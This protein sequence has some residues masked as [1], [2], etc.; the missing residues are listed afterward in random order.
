MSKPKSL[1]ERRE[2]N[3]R[4]RLAQANPGSV[5]RNQRNGKVVKQPEKQA[6]RGD[7]G[8]TARQ[9]QKSEIKS[10]K[11]TLKKIQG[12]VKI[13]LEDNLTFLI[14]YSAVSTLL[15]F[16]LLYNF[17]GALF[18][19][20]N[21]WVFVSALIILILGFVRILKLC[22]GITGKN[23]ITVEGVILVL[24]LS[25]T[26]GAF[27]SVVVN[28]RVYLST[29]E[30]AKVHGVTTDMWD[31][32][33]ILASAESLLLSVG[34]ESRAFYPE[35][36]ERS[37][38]LGKISVKWAKI[39]QQGSLPAPGLVEAASQLATS[40]DWGSRALIRKAQNIVEP[41]P[42]AEADVAEW[43][44]LYQ[45]SGS[46]AGETVSRVSQIYGI[47]LGDIS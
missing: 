11:Q 35:M 39:S 31:D 32:L 29:S 44:G 17:S 26:I 34:A 9:A 38:E 46:A 23:K 22:R 12:N 37:K 33:R 15:Y 47:K 36:E 14:I 2:E 28:G 40:A 43:I 41:D 18:K 19:N 3:E 13:F 30:V 4:R 8:K 7:L 21:I 42:K 5:A 27:N 24:V 10:V 1:R 25:F 20:Q 45:Q 16:W 6:R